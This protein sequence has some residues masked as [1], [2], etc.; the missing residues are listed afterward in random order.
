MTSSVKTAKWAD[1][2]AL[3]DRLRR[4]VLEEPGATALALRQVVA[5]RTFRVDRVR[6]QGLQ[7]APS[8]CSRV[9]I[10]DLG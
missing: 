9:A 6:S 8:S 1:H 2:S 3:A 10:S 4:R 7:R 5:P